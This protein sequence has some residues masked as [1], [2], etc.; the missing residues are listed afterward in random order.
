[1]FNGLENLKKFQQKKRDQSCSK[2][3]HFLR[4]ELRQCLYLSVRKLSN[5]L[6]HLSPFYG[7]SLNIF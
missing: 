2:D 3:P 6:L 5:L 4:I 7:A 1:M